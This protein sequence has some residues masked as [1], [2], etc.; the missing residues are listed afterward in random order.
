M[1]DESLFKGWLELEAPDG[2]RCRAVSRGSGAYRV[3]RQRGDTFIHV[4]VV[5]V[6]GAPEA[7]YSAP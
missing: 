1:N 6:D 4:G 3:Y 2:R 7:I 5:T